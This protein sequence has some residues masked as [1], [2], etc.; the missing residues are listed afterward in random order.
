MTAQYHT[1][2]S[3]LDYS[4]V[5]HHQEIGH[6]S[7]MTLRANISFDISQPMRIFPHEYS[8]KINPDQKYTIAVCDSSSGIISHSSTI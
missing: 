4:S 2:D 5:F 3:S 7:K 6:K 8:D 1:I